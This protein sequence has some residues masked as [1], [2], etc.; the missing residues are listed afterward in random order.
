M[1]PEEWAAELAELS[2]AFGRVGRMV[3]TAQPR[4]ADAPPVVLPG[5]SV[6]PALVDLGYVLDE[7]ERDE[8]GLYP[9]LGEHRPEWRD[10]LIPPLGANEQGETA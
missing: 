3:E 6:F 7:L 10:E 9:L 2:A 8:Q 1:T 5:P 4:A